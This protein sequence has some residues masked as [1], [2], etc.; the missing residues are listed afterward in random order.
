MAG[1][2]LHQSIAQALVKIGADLDTKTMKKKN[3]YA[4]YCQK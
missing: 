3:T 4:F 1:Y 2:F